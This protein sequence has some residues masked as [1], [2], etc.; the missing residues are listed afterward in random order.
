MGIVARLNNEIRM[1]GSISCVKAGTSGTKDEAYAKIYS[2]KKPEDC[3]VDVEYCLD[4]TNKPDCNYKGM[5]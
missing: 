1:Q 2:A 5:Y 3:K 4:C